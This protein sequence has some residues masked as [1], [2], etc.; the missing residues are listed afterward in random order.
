MAIEH[1]LNVTE[2]AA[3][4]GRQQMFHRGHLGGAQI[5]RGAQRA[6]ARLI[7]PEPDRLLHSGQAHMKPRLFRWTELH[8]GH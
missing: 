8:C 2:T 7:W 3:R 1:D 5:Q 4:Q 6:V